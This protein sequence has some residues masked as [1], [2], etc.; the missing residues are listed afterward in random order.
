MTAIVDPE[1]VG[2]RRT[3]EVLTECSETGVVIHES[4]LIRTDKVESHRV[5]PTSQAVVGGRGPRSNREVEVSEGTVRHTSTTSE[6][7]DEGEVVPRS[8][9]SWHFNAIATEAKD[10]VEDRRCWEVVDVER[11]VPVSAMSSNSN[12]SI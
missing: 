1:R 6:T 3:L 8:R 7:T 10:R 9:R 2:T 12:P 11:L 4:N 5:E